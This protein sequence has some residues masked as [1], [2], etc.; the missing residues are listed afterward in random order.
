MSDFK[1]LWSVMSIYS[2]NSK[3]PILCALAQ[4][5][6]TVFWETGLRMVQWAETCR[7]V[8]N[9]GYQ[10]MLCYWPNKLLSYCKHNWMAAIEILPV[11]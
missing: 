9:I 4:C 10:Y 6:S 8:F 3:N 2:V 11:R 7:Q 1:D 5:T